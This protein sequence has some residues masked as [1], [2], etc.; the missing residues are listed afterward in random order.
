MQIL[1]QS[2][3]HLILKDSVKSV[4]AIRL[5]CTP[6]LLIGCLGLFVVILEKVFP[7][8][9]IIFCL[10]VGISGVFL[11]AVT[12]V[13]LDKTQNRLNIKVQRLFTKTEQDYSLNVMSVR[14]KEIAL[15]VKKKSIYIVLLEIASRSRPIKLSGN[16]SFTQ[17]EAVKT[18]NLIKSFLYKSR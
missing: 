18:V 7:S 10:Y 8:I 17:T 14:V 13:T 3:T 11:S 1:E 2:A 6:F 4:L 16:Y 15:R 12:T 5:C 9:F